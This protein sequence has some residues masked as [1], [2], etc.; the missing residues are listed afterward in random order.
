MMAEPIP[1]LEVAKLL[2][3]SRSTMW[4]LVSE[5]GLTKHRKLGKGKTTYLDLDEVHRKWK[6]RPI[7]GR[8]DG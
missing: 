1:L 3:V 4:S 5:L 6:A 8:Q 2:G 7:E